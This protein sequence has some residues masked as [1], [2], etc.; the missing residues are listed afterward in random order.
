MFANLTPK[1]K[2]IL[3]F[4][5]S[6]YKKEG[7][8][9]SLAEIAK[10]FKKSVPTIHQF[11]ETLK[12]KGFLDKEEKIWR[13]IIPQNATRE[14]FL[15]GYI[16]AGR[17]IEPIENPEPIQIPLSMIS[18]MGNYYALKAQGNSM[19]DDG[20][21]DGDTIVVKHQNTANNGEMVV[22]ITEKG[23]T[24]KVFKKKNGQI[25]LEPR[26]KNLK[27]IQPRQIEIRGKFTGLIR[28]SQP[29]KLA[30]ETNGLKAEFHDL[31]VKYLQETDINHRKATG[32]YFT[33]RTIR[34]ELL[35]HLP[36]NIK[37]PK[38]LDPACGTGEFLLSACQYFNNPKLYGWEIEEKLIEIAR[39][40]VPE[41]YLK[42][43]DS[44]YE[45]TKE[46]FDF[47]IGNPPYFEFKPKNG[48][49]EKFQS[50][51]N[52]RPNIFSFFIKLGLDLLKPGGYLA[53]VVPPS[54]NNGLY[55]AELRKYIIQQGNI[56]YLSILNNSKLFHRAL[57]S[58]MLLVIKKI[59]NKGDYIFRKNGITIF[60]EKPERLKKSFENKTTLHDLGYTV[61]TGRLVWNQNKDLLTNEKN[62]IPL[63]WSHNITENGLKLTNHNKKYQYVKIDDCD[64][65]PAIVVNRITG[66]VKK[67]QLKAAIIPKQMKFIAEN[68]V[69]VIFP[70]S[71]NQQLSLTSAAKKS[72]KNDLQKIVN[73]L[74][75]K[76]KLAVLQYITGN[77]QISKTELE[78]LFPLNIN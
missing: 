71:E 35:N 23:A 48:L 29:E 73:Q 8:S 24:L 13:G 53:Y 47:V 34:E 52:G 1:Q 20:I 32:Q 9:P 54:M 42:N 78:K 57:Q 6:F 56:E 3:D 30:T 12:E 55:F 15:L 26:N 5:T 63:I 46:K 4:I 40:I 62:N 44:L 36:K 16:A 75:S 59:K 2:R 50:V 61:K 49:K 27:I 68:H 41:A 39:Q 28:N 37:N 10:R 19:I 22:A 51:V 64:F 66:T 14:I 11:I 33:P 7:Y 77:T 18:P 65:G 25:F 76:E 31:T 60:T 45:S 70:P 38:V 67:G 43:T 74:T 58:T 21:M 17:P 69:N 72:G